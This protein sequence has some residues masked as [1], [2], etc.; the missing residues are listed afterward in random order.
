MKGKKAEERAA[1]GKSEKAPTKEVPKADIPGKAEKT[2]EK[3]EP[4]KRRGR[5]SKGNSFKGCGS[6]KRTRSEN[7][8]NSRSEESGK[9][10]RSQKGTAEKRGF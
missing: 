8:E 9:R 7:R 6:E 3:Q 2:A 1:P 10:I 5:P 4:P